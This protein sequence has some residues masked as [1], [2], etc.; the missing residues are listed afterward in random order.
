MKPCKQCGYVIPA[1][2]RAEDLRAQ[3]DGFCGVGCQEV[4]NA[5]WDYEKKRAAQG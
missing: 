1:G 5:I 3:K 2:G 4:Y